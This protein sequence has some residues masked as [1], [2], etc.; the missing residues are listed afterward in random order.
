M[1]K[2]YVKNKDIDKYV[3]LLYNLYKKINY[4]VEVQDCNTIQKNSNLC[5]TFELLS[6]LRENPS[7]NNYY[8]KTV[9]YKKNQISLHDIVDESD[10]KVAKLDEYS[11]KI[12]LKHIWFETNGQNFKD[13]LKDAIILIKTFF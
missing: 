3:T 11:G 10:L 1:L 8:D 12:L 4:S 9:N 7:F 13:F 2:K 5:N 6:Y